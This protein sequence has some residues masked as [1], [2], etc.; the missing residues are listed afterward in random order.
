MSNQ[1]AQLQEATINR[2]RILP[3]PPNRRKAEERSQVDLTSE[4]RGND[5]RWKAWKT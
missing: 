4:S 2:N 5:G 1:M 3:L